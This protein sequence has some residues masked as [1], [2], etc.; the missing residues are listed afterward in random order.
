MSQD[1]SL[2]VTNSF[3]DFPQESKKHLAGLGALGLGSLITEI[4]ASEDDS[5]EA[6]GTQLDEEGEGLFGCVCGKSHVLVPGSSML[7]LVYMLQWG[8]A[9]SLVSD[10]SV[11]VTLAVGLHKTELSKLEI[12]V[13]ENCTRSR[14]ERQHN[15][16]PMVF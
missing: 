9:L 15:Q 14:G 6:D 11:L 8:P 2:P 4:T 1:S 10:T 5:S 16:V 7:T 3:F 12:S 13:C